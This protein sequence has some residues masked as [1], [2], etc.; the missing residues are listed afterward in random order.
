[1][2]PENL[3]DLGY[4]VISTRKP[5]LTRIQFAEADAIYVDDWS[6]AINAVIHIVSYSSVDHK[7]LLIIESEVYALPSAPSSA[8]SESD[9]H[10]EE[11]SETATSGWYEGKLVPTC[12]LW[13]IRELTHPSSYIAAGKDLIMRQES[14]D[15]LAEWWSIAEAG[16]DEID[17]DTWATEWLD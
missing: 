13:G 4:T 10:D 2:N 15:M 3:C 8:S 17:W 1:M 7:D 6:E 9:D 16:S 5:R 14:W 11:A 12:V